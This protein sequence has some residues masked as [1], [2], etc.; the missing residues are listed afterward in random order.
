MVH[1]LAVQDAVGV[2][3]LLEQ[4]VWENVVGDL[5]FLQAQHIGL[6]IA[7]ELL[8]DIGAGADAVD[9][10]SGDAKRHGTHLGEAL[11]LV[12]CSETS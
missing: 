9:V 4:A 6:M 12:T 1:A 8:H 11:S 2:A 3:Q 7:Q 5:G 10:P